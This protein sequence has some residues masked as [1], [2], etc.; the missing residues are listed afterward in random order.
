MLTDNMNQQHGT[1]I[2]IF[3]KSR[4]EQ[5]EDDTR[6]KALSELW[7]TGQQEQ[8]RAWKGLWFIV[9]SHNVKM[10]PPTLAPFSHEP[11]W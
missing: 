4:E 1:Q 11:C 9:Q 8:R 5:E 3:L 6:G 7:C 2:R 10:A